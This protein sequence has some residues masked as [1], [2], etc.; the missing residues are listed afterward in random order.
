VTSKREK[1]LTKE[2][3]KSG[4][5]AYLISRGTSRNRV[6]FDCCVKD[7]SEKKEKGKKKGCENP[8][9]NGNSSLVG[10]NRKSS[11]I[12]KWGCQDLNRKSQRKKELK[13]EKKGEKHLSREWGL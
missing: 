9:N 5:R 7:V 1:D 11:T 13:S 8:E 4:D 6:H 3:S 12:D 10:K 2:A